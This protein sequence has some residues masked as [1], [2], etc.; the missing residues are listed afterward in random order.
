[1]LPIALKLGGG[2]IADDRKKPRFKWARQ[3]VGVPGFEDC[4]QCF[5]ADVIDFHLVEHS[6]THKQGN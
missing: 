5:L 6:P 4:K 1:M 3:L 2:N